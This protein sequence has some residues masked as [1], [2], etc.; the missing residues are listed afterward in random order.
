M[1]ITHGMNVEQVRQIGRKLQAEAEK[2]G[3]VMQTVDSQVQTAQTAWKGPDSQQFAQTWQ[4]H[5]PQLQKLKSELE[6]LSKK[7]L[8]NAE[9]QTS[10]SSSF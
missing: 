4:G 6:T 9:A 7:A 5:R 8:S 2:I 1:A 3:Q 10:T